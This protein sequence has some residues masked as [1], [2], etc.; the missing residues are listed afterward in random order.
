MDVWLFSYTCT[1][2]NSLMKE[3][4]LKP[5]LLV[6]LSNSSRFKI[7]LSDWESFTCTLYYELWKIF[8]VTITSFF[9]IKILRFYLHMHVYWYLAAT[10]V[11]P[12]TD[13]SYCRSISDSEI[14]KQKTEHGKYRLTFLIF[15]FFFF[16]FLFCFVFSKWLSNAET[17]PFN[18][19]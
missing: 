12:A 6:A 16:F 18:F 1:N 15:H 2:K 7:S 10:S 14:T 19:T 5:R 11:T 9:S 3:S 17:N 13:R 4:K 8:V